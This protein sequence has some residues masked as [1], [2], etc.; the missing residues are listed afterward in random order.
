MKKKNFLIS[1]LIINFNN[2]KLLKRAIKS[3][4][5]QNYE[6][7]E[8]L[9]FDD[10]S[11]D[12]FVKEIKKIKKN[13]K[14]RFFQNKDIKKKTKIASFDAKNGYYFLIKKSRGNVIC[15][16][17]S[18]DYFDK[19]KISVVADQFRKFKKANFLQNLPNLKNNQKNS[20]LSFWPYL[21]PESCISFRRKFVKK[22]MKKNYKLQNKFETVWLGFRLGTYAY[23]VDKSFVF[24]K[25][26][27]THYSS[28][29]ESKKYPRFGFN[30]F[31]RRMNS[32]EY[33][34]LITNK[35]LYFKLNLDFLVTF[36][37]IKIYKFLKNFV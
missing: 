1:I 17:D 19:S 27:L 6:N 18:D 4:L 20:L 9:V 25:K 10:C 33:L 11:T 35:K 34:Y 5:L 31:E 7:I 8:I 26:K 36:I 14:I 23:F 28:H 21:A 3:C 2:S 16:L 12:N 22:F 29:G 32:F 37:I 15:L 24:C 30:W 13:N